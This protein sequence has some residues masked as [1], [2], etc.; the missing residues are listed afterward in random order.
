MH[1]R[2]R[3]DFTGAPS[4]P[5]TSR[6][7]GT[8]LSPPRDLPSTPSS[9]NG[10]KRNSHSRIPISTRRMSATSDSGNSTQSARANSA[11]GRAKIKSTTRIAGPTSK[12]GKKPQSPPQHSRSILRRNR[13]IEATLVWRHSALRPALTLRPTYRSRCLRSLLH[14]AAQNLANQSRMHQ[15]QRRA[16]ASL[17]DSPAMKMGM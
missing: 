5:P 4:R 6:F 16:R 15:H 1:R 13:H 7:Y 2:T 3:S 17:S 12:H 9:A 14:Y 8:N 11:L 10:S